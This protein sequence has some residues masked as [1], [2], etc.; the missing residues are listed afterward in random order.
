MDLQLFSKTSFSDF[1][2]HCEGKLRHVVG[3][4]DK[5]RVSTA[6]LDELS[7]Q[8][9]SGISLAVPRLLEEKMAYDREPTQM[10]DPF[11]HFDIVPGVKTTLVIPFEGDS[12]LFHVRPSSW[13]T[14]IPFGSLS[15]RDELTLAEEF[16]TQNDNAQT[17]KQAFDQ[18]ILKIKQYLGTLTSDCDSLKKELRQTSRRLI[19]ARR[20]KIKKEEEFANA[21]GIPRRS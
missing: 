10:P 13:G 5:K 9:V 19:E 1:K 2:Q 7:D 14:S 17:A 6:D 21:M 12:D 4:L 15:S 16:T 20:A 18:R 11:G 3:Q 8:L